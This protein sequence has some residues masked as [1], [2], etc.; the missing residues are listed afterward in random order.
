MQT[1]L[2]Y[3][4]FDATAAVLDGRRLGKQRV[5]TM[6]I[7][8]ALVFP[9][10]RGWKNHPAT[11][12]WRGFTPALVAYGLAVCAEWERRGHADAVGPG[13]L[14][15][16]GG[17]VPDVAALR[18]DGQLPPWLGFEPFHL[19]HRSALVRKDPEHYRG[20]FPDVPDDLP[21]VWPPPVFPRWP[22]RRG[23]RALGVDEAAAELGWAAP[24][25]EQRQ[26]VE[27][28]RAGRDVVLDWPRGSGSTSAA[29]LAA[30]CLPGRTVWVSHLEPLDADAPAVDTLRPAPVAARPGR[31]TPSIA[32]EPTAEDRAALA[33]EA[34]EPPEFVFLPRSRLAA[35]GR[36]LSGVSLLVFDRV[37]NGR[38]LGDA[39]RLTLR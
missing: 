29:L 10:Y 26:A 22:V 13:L 6:Q 2:P 34:A 32:R 15:F 33:A 31:V 36:R 25:P 3:A 20:Y 21:Y 27:A 8:R 5:E 39:V 12:M 11:K 1:F 7:L 28:L 18:R 4:D 35:A 14:D 30:L 9:S 37:P 38:R 16:T 19:S 17:R 24:Y 23:E